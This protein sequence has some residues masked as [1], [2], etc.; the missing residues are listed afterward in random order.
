MVGSSQWASSAPVDA[1]CL[2]RHAI[3]R[4]APEGSP[5]GESCTLRRGGQSLCN[6]RVRP[7]DLSAG[8]A[9]NPLRIAEWGLWNPQSEIRNPKFL[10]PCDDFLK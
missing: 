3:L 5:G 7:E 1:P 2:V 4:G 8:F 9:R 6:G 10:P